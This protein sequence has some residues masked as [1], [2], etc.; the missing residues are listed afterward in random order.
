MSCQQ[1]GGWRGKG[2]KT[3]REPCSAELTQ[4]Y[5][6]VEVDLF[7]DQIGAVEDVNQ[8]ALYFHRLARC[9]NP[10]PCATMC[11]AESGL[12]NDDIVAVVDS[13]LL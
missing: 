7:A 4:D 6:E 13:V 8:C 11:R 9:G 5:R 1:A 12:Y 2:R 10:G 3:A